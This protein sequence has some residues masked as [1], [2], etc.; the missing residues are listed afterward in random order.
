MRL[1]NRLAVVMV[2]T[3]LLSLPA[4]AVAAGNYAEV[5][6]TDGMAAPPTA[7]EDREIRFSLLQHG[8]TPVDHGEVTLTATSPGVAPVTVVATSLGNGAWVAT[9]T[10]PSAGD[11]QLRVTHSEF[12]TPPAIKV[13][14]AQAAFSWPTS[15]LPI[16]GIGMAAVILLAGAGLLARRTSRVPTPTTEPVGR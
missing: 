6:Y 14:V 7:G 3:G 9:V 16:V 4:G 15:V 1:R 11:W 5:G 10:F 12:E 8:I 13:S 2:A